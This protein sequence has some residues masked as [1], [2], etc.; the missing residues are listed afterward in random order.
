MKADKNKLLHPGENKT[1]KAHPYAS[2]LMS[3]STSTLRR[4]GTGEKE[5]LETELHEAGKEK[6]QKCNTRL[7]GKELKIKIK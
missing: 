7:R 2:A 4:N 1:Q 5:L 3:S 6:N